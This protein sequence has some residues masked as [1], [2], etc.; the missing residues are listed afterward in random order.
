MKA[1]QVHILSQIDIHKLDEARLYLKKALDIIKG[2]EVTKLP[3][4]HLKFDDDPIRV[5]S[6]S[7]GNIMAASFAIDNSINVNK[8]IPVI[9]FDIHYLSDPD[10]NR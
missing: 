7:K 4:V 10:G 3:N 8:T 6:L 1:K 2:I 5:L 9:T